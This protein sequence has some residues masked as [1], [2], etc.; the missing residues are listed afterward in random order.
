MW[1]VVCRTW[2][3][4]PRGRHCERRGSGSHPIWARNASWAREVVLR[5]VGLPWGRRIWGVRGTCGWWSTFILG[6]HV[7]LKHTDLYL[8]GWRLVGMGEFANWGEDARLKAGLYKCRPRVV[9]GWVDII[10][11]GWQSLLRA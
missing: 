6:V 9:A 7:P 4:G 10:E 1:G 5:R 3:R 11:S 8:G 2:I